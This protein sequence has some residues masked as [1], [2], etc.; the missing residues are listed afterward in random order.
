MSRMVGAGPSRSPGP[1]PVAA[2]GRCKAALLSLAM[3]RFCVARRLDGAFETMGPT[4]TP[5]L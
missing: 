5:A 3:A 1:L 2:W 4:Q